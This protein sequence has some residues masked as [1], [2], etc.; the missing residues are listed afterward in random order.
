MR[1]RATVEHFH[2]AYTHLLRYGPNFEL[3]PFV[4]ATRMRFRYAAEPSVSG[5]R[6]VLNT[7]RTGVIGGITPRWR[8]NE[9]V[10]IELRVTGTNGSGME[11]FTTDAGLLL[12]PI[13]NLSLR[14]GYSKREHSVRDDLSLTL[15]EV[16]AKGPTARLQ[17]DF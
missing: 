3:E 4:G 16:D 11:G 8:F 10:A 17:F 6:P 9:W 13:P 7:S 5:V 2:V 14:L 15:V 1:Q 12:S